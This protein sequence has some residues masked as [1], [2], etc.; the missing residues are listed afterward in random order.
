MTDDESESSVS[1]QIT[2]QCQNGVACGFIYLLNGS[3]PAEEAAQVKY[4]YSVRWV[5]VY[6]RVAVR[7]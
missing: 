1:R 4:G 3:L 7:G 6:G 5:G 2:E